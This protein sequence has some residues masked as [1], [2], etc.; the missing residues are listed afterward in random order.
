MPGQPEDLA[1]G[2]HTWQVSEGALHK[3]WPHF[4]TLKVT[5]EAETPH[6]QWEAAGNGQQAVP[7]SASQTRIFFAGFLARPESC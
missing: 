1:D 5:P 6:S 7:G 3:S 4:T 2:R